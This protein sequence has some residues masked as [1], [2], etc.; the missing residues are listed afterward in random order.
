MSGTSPGEDRSIQIGQDANG[1]AIITGDGNV[2]IFQTARVIREEAVATV[3][4]VGPN[5]YKGLLAFSEEDANDFFGREKQVATL[6]DKLRALLDATAGHDGNCR[7]LAVLGPSGSGKSSVVRAGLIP[8]LARR[9][10]PGY[11]QARVAVFTPGTHPIEALA[12]RLAHIATNDPVPVA[13]T[14]EFS[15]EL[16]LST[17]SGTYDGLRRIATQLPNV[18]V[19]PL[20]IL[21]DQFEE[22]YSICRDKDEQQQFINNILDAAADRSGYVSVIL[23]LRS[24]F[25]GETSTHRLLNNII[26]QQNVIVPVM[27]VD[28]LRRAITEPAKRSGYPLDDATVELLINETKDREGTLPLLQFALT[29]IWE[30][31]EQGVQPAVTLQ[32]MGGVGGAL[33]AEARRIYESLPPKDQQTA[34][35]VFLGL[36]QLGEGT[37][38]TRRRVALTK[39]MSYADDPEHVDAVINRFCSRDT[40][41]VTVSA[42]DGTETVEV[43]H[44][45]LF[46]HWEMFRKWLDESRD[47]VRFHQRLD[48]AADNWKDQGRPRGSLWRPPDLDRLRKFQERCGS[49]MT[50]LQKDFFEASRKAQDRRRYGKFAA[51]IGLVVIAVLMALLAGVAIIHKDLAE[52]TAERL[53]IALQQAGREKRRALD[54]K[55]LADQE[56]NKALAYLCGNKAREL[57]RSPDCVGRKLEQAILLGTESLQ[58]LHTSD[59]VGRLVRDGLNCL[60]PR[61]ARY[62]GEGVAAV[63][64]DEEGKVLLTA[65][66]DQADS[67]GTVTIRAAN[68]VYPCKTCTEES[69]EV[70]VGPAKQLAVSANRDRIATLQSPES[71]VVW[72]VPSGRK[73]PIMI[74]L[75]KKTADVSFALSGNGKMVAI[76]AAFKQLKT[77]PDVRTS[78][79]AESDSEGPADHKGPKSQAYQGGQVKVWDTMSESP[80][81]VL[82]VDDNADTAVALS[83]DGTHVA[84]GDVS[85]HIRIWR[86][87]DK[88]QLRDFRHTWSR[89]GGASKIVGVALDWDAKYV[90][91]QTETGIIKI[92]RLEGDRPREIRR[93]R[94][95]KAQGQVARA[96]LALGRYGFAAHQ[97]EHTDA[98]TP[99]AKGT[100][101]KYWRK[102][103]HERLLANMTSDDNALIRE[104]RRRISQ[105][106][107]RE[108]WED[109]VGVVPTEYVSA[110]SGKIVGDPRKDKDLIAAAREDRLDPMEELVRQGANINATDDDGWT[111]LMYAV[112]ADHKETAVSLLKHGATP[113]ALNHRGLSALMIACMKGHKSMVDLLLKNGA[114]PAIEGSGSQ[115][116]LMM[117]A[118]GG[119]VGIVDRLLAEPTLPKSHRDDALLLVIQ[120][121]RSSEVIPLLVN[122]GA[123]LDTKARGRQA[124]RAA[125]AKGDF[126]T[127]KLLLEKSIDSNARDTRGNTAMMLASQKGKSEVVRFLLEKGADINV[128]NIDGFNALS[129][130]SQNG[131]IEVVRM[132][133]DKGADVNAA[134]TDGFTALTRA[135]Q[136][137][138]IEVVRMLLDKGAYVD[139]KT[140]Y[141]STPLAWA[142]EKGHVEVVRILLD[143]G[144]DVNARNDKGGSPL[145]LASDKGHLQVVEMLLDKGADV[146]AR[147]IYGASA[148][149]Y[150]A[151]NEKSDVVRVLLERGANTNV[152]NEKGSTPLIV[153]ASKGYLE[154]VR[155]VLDKGADVNVKTISGTSALVYAARNGKSEMVKALLERGADINLTGPNGSTS[156]IMAAEKGH[157]EVVQ[158]LLDKG[159]DVNAKNA[160]GTSP[161][162]YAAQNGKSE[163]VKVLLERGADINTTNHKGSTPMTVAAGIGH[164]EV[165]QMLLDKKADVNTRNVYGASPLT[166]AAQNGKSQVVEL[167]LGTGADVNATN[168]KGSTLLL[169]ASE[170]GHL[171]VVRM[172][173]DKGADVNAKNVF[174]SNPLV[175]A[176]QNGKSEVVKALLERGADTGATNARGAT[177]LLLAAYNGHLEVVRML[178]EKAADVNTKTIYGSSALVHAAKNGHF[179]VVKALLENG[180]DTGATNEKGATPLALAAEKGHHKVV[181]AL[182][183]KAADCHVEDA[184]GETAL[185]KAHREGHDSVVELLKKHGAER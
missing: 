82:K 69:T 30:G 126:I 185:A 18:G 86:I 74:E 177:P 179:K 47:D 145:S 87:A 160:Y 75:G 73:T 183:D 96:P 29:R 166:Y 107:S 149:T 53:E 144:A 78:E 116:A 161:L 60:P 169:L 13:K 137:G 48:E 154:V 23:T 182:L 180:A 113:D 40:R 153:A 14:R 88:K 100:C 112:S 140:V 54:A 27:E 173:L 99:G 133:L 52:K 106:L 117:A 123:A 109:L 20:Y 159:A 1:N 71:V 59:E 56:R 61:A 170:N 17:A 94:A 142:S 168:Q 50:L 95:E 102:G 32:K 143:K 43:T 120:H 77:S 41:L 141:C 130:A 163:V 55:K 134:S 51:V 42:E 10:L 155:M 65:H 66:H 26:S 33:A 64:F 128:R 98:G 25:L 119:D 92:W 28:E 132:L 118:L 158:M 76:V 80:K 111:P 146:N 162:G 138:H 31:L 45:A 81:E 2:V 152:T 35:R 62:N 79:E 89:G 67:T 103:T 165:V 167:M 171:D 139:A 72:D 131:H 108:E 11:K 5:P 129:F 114:S 101:I 22:L 121:G 105:G 125:A 127:V 91:A 70:K 6:W 147:N 15:E 93:F 90:A 12:G 16:R 104:A 68:T 7:L 174:G 122:M 46:D 172:L 83:G 44:E 97:I 38:D 115:T 63:W 58:R 24:D 21:V 175:Y 49:D 136:N 176:A 135:S 178:L 184:N 164:V 37:R 3:T 36:V 156:V 34:R 9:P 39:L 148:L 19:Q 151:Q 150:A 124:F 84:V 4:A 85:G 57:W 181:K 110:D 157:L 8:E